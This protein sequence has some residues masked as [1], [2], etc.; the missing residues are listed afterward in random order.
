MGHRTDMTS[1]D[2][3]QAAAGALYGACVGDAA[4]AVLEFLAHDPTRADVQRALTF[5]GGGCW[6][7]APGQI[8][9]DSELTLTLATSLVEAGGF[10]AERTARGYAG[11]YTSRPFDVG[12][13]TAR[14][15]SAKAREGGTLADAMRAAAREG[16][17]GSKANGSLMRATPLGVVGRGKAPEEVAAIASADSALSHPNP[18]CCEAVAVYA[19][20][21]ASLVEAPGDRARAWARANGWAQRHAGNEVIGWL[22][23]AERGE[24][25]PYSPQDGFVR[26]GF[27]HA[28]RHFLASTPWVAAI[29]ETLEGGGDTDTNACI[30]GGLL[31]AASPGDIPRAWI[32]AVTGADV[33]R[34]RP[35]PPEY[36]PRRVA[37][38]ITALMA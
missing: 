15:F 29:E 27:V 24:A 1:T 12:Q 26:I 25:V 7:V 33:S 16:S 9:D 21:I 5:P 28:F 20:A 18:S 32:D 31:G 13:T 11:W 8:T 37:Q 2:A 34:G 23:L 6:R 3:T 36:H 17:M 35:R 14:A 38:L 19:I 30:V 4:G 22:A 10:D